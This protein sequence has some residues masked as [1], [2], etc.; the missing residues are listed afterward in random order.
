MEKTLAYVALLGFVLS[1]LVHLCALAGIDVATAVPAV[2]GLHFAIFVLFI[3]FMLSLNK[4]F[5]RRVRLSALA[6]LLPRWVRGLMFVLFAY[7]VVNFFLF[8]AAT[9]GGSP[10]Q[11]ENGQFILQSHGKLIRVLTAQEYTAFKAN[12][13]RGFSGHWLLFYFLPFAY[14]CF[15]TK[16]NADADAK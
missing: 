5:G 11:Q 16:N 3:P 14:F 10:S 6:Q 4:R 7:V 12:E 2:Y 8:L 13:V 15:G 1:L 9:G